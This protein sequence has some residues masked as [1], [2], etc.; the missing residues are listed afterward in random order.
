MVE[1]RE[2]VHAELREEMRALEAGVAR[3]RRWRRR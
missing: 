2:Q 3:T 1:V